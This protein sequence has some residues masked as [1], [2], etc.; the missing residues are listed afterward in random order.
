VL[1]AT[2]RRGGGVQDRKFVIPDFLLRLVS[3]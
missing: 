3:G 1:Y 2:T